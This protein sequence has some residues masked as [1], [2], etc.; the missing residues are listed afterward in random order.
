MN[1][2]MLVSAMALAVAGCTTTPFSSLKQSY[3]SVVDADNETVGSIF[4]W[5]NDVNAAVVYKTGV[6][7]AQR[8]MTSVTADSRLTLDVSDA[9]GSLSQAVAT[10]AAASAETAATAANNPNVDQSAT[11]ASQNQALLDLAGS[12]KETAQSLTTSTERTA[13]L[14]VGMFYLCQLANN[15]T[16]SA[17]G[18]A[19]LT[20]LLIQEAGG[21]NS[22]VTPPSLPGALIVPGLPQIPMIPSPP[23]PVVGVHAEPVRNQ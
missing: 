10:T 8:A 9:I 17:D 7:C 11:Q 12:I 16:L 18:S 13:F 14:D 20:A 22:A 2:V 15:G 6:I 3:R 21:L 1:K 5:S 19:F 23:E 4:I